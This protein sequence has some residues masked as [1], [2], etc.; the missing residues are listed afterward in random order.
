MLT[1]LQKNII[2]KSNFIWM[3]MDKDV[4][5]RV[6][7]CTIHSDIKIT[8][9]IAIKEYIEKN[10]PTPVKK[11]FNWKALSFRTEWVF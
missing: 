8:D 6:L 10:K 3:G 1:V 11:I 9:Y 2:R 7:L 5:K 4:K